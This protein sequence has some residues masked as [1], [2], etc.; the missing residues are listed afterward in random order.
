M[1]KQFKTATKKKTTIEFDL[2]DD[3]YH[4]TAPKFA[5]TFLAIANSG[6]DDQLTQGRAVLNWLSTGLPEE[7]NALLIARLTD[8]HDDLDFDDL[9]PVFEYLMQQ[10]TGRPTKPQRA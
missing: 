8:P 2:D 7:E 9:Q 5:G 6:S 4:F 10:V 1:G 3:T